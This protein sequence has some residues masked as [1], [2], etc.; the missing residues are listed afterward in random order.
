M[1]Y[2]QYWIEFQYKKKKQHMPPYI[3]SQIDF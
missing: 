2:S 3:N 1:K